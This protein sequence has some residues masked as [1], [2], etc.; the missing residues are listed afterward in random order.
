MLEFSKDKYSKNKNVE[1]IKSDSIEYL[2]NTTEKF[3]FIYS[4]WSFSHSTHQILTKKSLEKGMIF[5]KKVISKV[6]IENMKKGS[7]FY[8]V[9][10]D[11]MSDEQTILLKQW[12]KVFPI[13]RDVSKQSP[14]KL[15]M[16]QVC[17]ELLSE[18]IIDFE[19]QHFVGEPIEYG[20]INEAL[21]VFLNFHMESYFNESDDVEE[22]INELSNYFENF[23]EESGKISIKPGCF[24]YKI[25][26]L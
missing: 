26:R 25:R 18:H 21:E 15:L 4:L 9:H 2:E 11:S 24:I 19:T 13:F 14:S 20:S 1:F 23:R 7:Y 16:D 8:L 6:I 5:L 22:I 17:N 10:F 12:R 3:D